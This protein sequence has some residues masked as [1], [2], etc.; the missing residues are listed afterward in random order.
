MNFEDY[1]PWS[2]RK[3]GKIMQDILKLRIKTIELE[4]TFYKEKTITLVMIIVRIYQLK[5]I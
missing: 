3:H 5:C 1:G 4:N 2:I